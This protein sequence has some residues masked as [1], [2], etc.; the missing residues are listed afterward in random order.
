MT[1]AVSDT[2]RYFV[3]YS[4]VKLP[5]KLLSELDL[6]QLGNRNTFFRGYFDG[7]DRLVKL[8]KVVYGEIEME[9]RYSYH[10][11]GT[12]KHADIIDAEGEVTGLDFA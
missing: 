9:H 7:C 10:S 12:L 1:E 8:Q 2:C 4:G 6:T 3:S 11:N 5:L